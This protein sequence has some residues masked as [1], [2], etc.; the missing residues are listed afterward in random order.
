MSALVLLL[1][2]PAPPQAAPVDVA[3]VWTV[4]VGPGTF[5]V[6]GRDVTL[7]K[8][9]VV[10]IQPPEIFHVLNERHSGLSVFD[11]KAGGWRKGARLRRV[12][13]QECTAT[14]LVDPESIKVRPGPGEP[15]FTLGVDYAIDGFWA[16]VGRL[17]GGA[18]GAGQE[19]CIDYDYRLSR[20]DTIC[21]DAA[22][23]LTVVQGEAAVALA[24][25]PPLPDG[26]TAIANIY[27]RGGIR[28]IDREHL[29]PIQPAKFAA[30]APV[31]EKL[32]PKTLAKLRA[33]QPVTIVAFG[34]SVTN[35][36][37]VEKAED[38][39]QNQFLVRLQERFPQADIRML[40]AA[41]GGASSKRY[42]EAPRGG[43]H[44]FVRDVLEPNPDLVTIEFVNDAYL[45]EA[46]VARHY[47]GIVEQIRGVGAEIVLITPHLV[48]PD[49]MGVESTM[50]TEDPRPYVK[51][52]KAFAAENKIALADASA[53]WLR[54]RVQGIP[55]QT[56]LANDIN[57][58]DKRGHAIFAEAL[59]ALLPDK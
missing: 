29:Y 52:L 36:G 45:D 33:G 42:L 30:P 19:V 22:G 16:T 1:A 3:G 21:A 39:Y 26:K 8:A 31:A 6:G 58:P 41:W 24:I 51:G 4:Q 54:L 11:E 48:R 43:E 17:E 55:Y 10:D 2:F 12:I 35:G 50:F 14:G 53:R 32:L 15:P 46:G 23:K 40:T 34:D 44:D 28:K 37:G 38:W 59:M 47:A 57:H 56:L 18:I 7:D 25:P 20:I 13:A 5:T 9:V 27:M 49:W